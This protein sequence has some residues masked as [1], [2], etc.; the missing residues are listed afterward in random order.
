MRSASIRS[1]LFA[2][3][4]FSRVYFSYTLS[5]IPPWE[6]AITHGWK[7]VAPGGKLMI[8]DFG[9]CEA[10]PSPFRSLL[11]WWLAKF[12]VTPRAKLHR[13]CRY[14]TPRR[15]IL[16]I[17]PHGGYARVCGAYATSERDVIWSTQPA[18]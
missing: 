8:V 1:S 14:G 13:A 15:S 3:P 2:A 4:L 6:S 18:L 12:H 7:H 5:M 16:G 10:L 17:P 11:W 9:Q